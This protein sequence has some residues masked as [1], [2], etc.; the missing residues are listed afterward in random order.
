MTKRLYVSLAAAAPTSQHNGKLIQTNVQGNSGDYLF[1]DLFKGAATWS[2]VNSSTTIPLLPTDLDSDGW[3][4]N[5]SAAGGQGVT[6]NFPI[7]SQAERSGLYILDWDGNGVCSTGSMSA[8]AHSISITGVSQS[9]GVQT[10]TMDSSPS[11]LRAGMAI[12]IS[13]FSGGSWAGAN[14]TVQIQSVDTVLNTISIDTGT[15]FTGTATLTNAKA[16]SVATTTVSNGTGFTGVGRYILQPGPTGTAQ[17]IKGF[18]GG[19]LQAQVSVLSVRSS[20]DYPREIRFYHQDDEAALDSG[21]LFSAIGLSLYSNVGCIR[22]LNW[23]FGSNN[24]CN[25][26]SWSHRKRMSYYSWMAYSHNSSLFGGQATQTVSSSGCLYTI[27]APSSFTSMVDKVTV[28]FYLDKH[29]Y[30]TVTALASDGSGNTIVTYSTGGLHTTFAE[31]ETIV[32]G[33]IGNGSGSGW[34]ACNGTFPIVA[35]SVGAGTLKIAVNT[36][37]ATGTPSFSNAFA[38]HQSVLLKVGSATAVQCTDFIGFSATALSLTAGNA[39]A[40]CTAVYDLGLNQFNVLGAQSTS[41]GG[42]GSSSDGRLRTSAPPELLF[43]LCKAVGAHPHMVTPPFALDDPTDWLPNLMLMARGYQVQCP[44]MVPRFE[45]PNELWNPINTQTQYSYAKGNQAGRSWGAAQYHDWY[46]MIMSLM[47]QI[48]EAVYGVR[49]G[50]ASNYAILCGIQTPT[51]T[52]ATNIGNARLESTKFVTGGVAPPAINV[53]G[54]GTISFSA[55]AAAPAT[56]S[57]GASTANNYVSHVCCAQYFN[58][59][60]ERITDGSTTDDALASAFNGCQFFA[61]MNGDGTMTV[62]SASSITF[63]T[64]IADGSMTLLGF[65]VPTGISIL[66]QVSG[67]AGG[68]GVYNVTASPTF[69]V[70]YQQVYFGAV[71][72]TAPDTLISYLDDAVANVSISGS[73]LTINSLTSGCVG[74]SA[75]RLYVYGGSIPFGT[76]SAAIIGGTH[77]TYT[78]RGSPGNVSNATMSIGKLFSV[79]GAQKLYYNS[80]QYGLN[81]NVVKLHGYEGGYSPDYTNTAGLSQGDQLRRAAKFTYYLA[82]CSVLNWDNFLGRTPGSLPVGVTAEFP[83]HFLI[84][85]SY[86]SNAYPAQGAWQMLEDGYVVPKPPVWTALVNY[87]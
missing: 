66:S 29:S 77:P 74:V 1:L 9:G 23:R 22:D 57:P 46:G 73:T 33:N 84:T 67:T 34:T 30:A 32:I 60:V 19:G 49:A 69:N 15:T 40:F 43:E 5:N 18:G 72:L 54:V 35:G 61:T 16:T 82:T 70:G 83:S 38:R 65:G 28:Q 50:A 48:G 55:V 59:N 68:P 2:P 36:A 71:D 63:G 79:A 25:I 21:Q 7:P 27:S 3:L 6:T 44:W 37:A 13:G 56:G 4:I 17:S 75:A 26:S 14:A 51:A 87:E 10:Y 45:G 42:S 53:S 24:T 41:S 86:P 58:S 52:S 62:V 80:A 85:G 47:G 12:A 78:L 31:G 81:H 64:I 20:S 39:N 8:V 76:Y 11:L